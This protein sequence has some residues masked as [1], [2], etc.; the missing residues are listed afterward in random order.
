MTS[1]VVYIGAPE[2]NAANFAALARADFPDLDLFATD[3]RP[4]ALDNLETVEAVIGHHF[5]F[6]AALVAGAPKLRWIQSLTSGTDAILK[7]PRLPREVVI[8][9]ARGMHGPQMSELVFLQ[10]LAL[11]RDLRRILRNQSEGRW[12]RWPQP[13]LWHK[14]VVIVGVGA[15]SEMLA[16]RCKAF[17]MK[18]YGVSGSTRVPSGFDAVFSRTQLRDA[19]ALADILVLIVPLTPETE[20]LVNER[21]LEAMKESAYLVNVARGGV[22]DES[23][24]IGRLRAGKLAGA[25]LD[26]FR[27]M[28]LPSDD[29][30]WRE[31]R[32]IVTPLLGG[33]SDVYLEQVYPLVR[34]NLRHFLANR[35]ESMVN[36]VPRS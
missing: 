12:E 23:A 8:T 26:V 5:Q 1:R 24:L 18:V 10:M 4:T 15:I 2:A 28:P 3:D 16:V 32:I 22:L 11:L 35:L 20:N 34:D 25:A 30:L 31:D 19:A 7:I 33:M 6:D 13:L 9:S 14:T 29:P 36:V 21:V 27:Q 17:D